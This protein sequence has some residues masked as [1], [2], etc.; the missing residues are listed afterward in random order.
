MPTRHTVCQ[1]EKPHPSERKKNFAMS[2]ERNVAHLVG[3]SNAM[4]YGVWVFGFFCSLFHTPR[5]NDSPFVLILVQFGQEY[6]KNSKT[7]CTTKFST[8]QSTIF[9]ICSGLHFMLV[10]CPGNKVFLRNL[11][12]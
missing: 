12:S 10:A 8:N 3:Q 9:C 6:H 2:E 1:I 11:V 5:F 4:R 7:S